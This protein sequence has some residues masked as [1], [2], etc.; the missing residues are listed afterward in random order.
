MFSHVKYSICYRQSAKTSILNR[1]CPE[2]FAVHAKSE[3]VPDTA[4]FSIVTTILVK[5]KREIDNTNKIKETRIVRN[6]WF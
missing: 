5:R 1:A 6:T 3:I 2:D 4:K